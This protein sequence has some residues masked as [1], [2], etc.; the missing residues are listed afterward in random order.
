MEEQAPSNAAVFQQLIPALSASLGQLRRSPGR[1]EGWVDP[2]LSALER[3]HPSLNKRLRRR[4]GFAL[5]L[6]ELAQLDMRERAVL[7]L[8]LFFHEL[9][10]EQARGASAR[11]SRPWTEYL[12]RNEHWLA[13]CYQLAQALDTEDWGTE[14]DR[15]AVVAKVAVVFDV[16]TLERH[17]RPLIVMQEMFV[18]AQ[19]AAAEQIIPIL[20]TED[21]QELCDHHFRRQ[22]YRVDVSE[23]KHALDE[24][25]RTAPRPILDE[26]P[27]APRRFS[28]QP[29]GRSQARPGAKP[30]AR[31][32]R[33][34][35][36]AAPSNGANQDFD[37]RRQAL[38][39]GPGWGA[40]LGDPNASDQ[41]EEELPP[42]PIDVEPEPL[43]AW[44]PPSAE[45]QSQEPTPILKH[46]TSAARDVREEER[47]MTTPSIASAKA[48]AEGAD[49]TARV[50][51]LRSRLASI[52]RAS[53]EAQQVLASFA[54]QVEELAAWVADLEAVVGRRRAA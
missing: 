22:S 27:D 13:P 17:G 19:S 2:T 28:A 33:E 20:W 21:G 12:V 7:T 46:Q 6:S 54:P 38:R 52:Q 5:R 26:A 24:L 47:P 40:L 42:P 29:L 16:E 11:G 39:A 43:A 34:A 30:A 10:D 45:P 49:I 3:D 44:E 32:R 50:E 48:G 53:A 4:L 18:N 25:K 35:A 36:A 31:K 9:A 15:A 51:E 37:R 23:V 8:G 14:A 1:T 41:N